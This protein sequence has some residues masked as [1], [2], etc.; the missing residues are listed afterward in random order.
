MASVPEATNAPSLSTIPPDDTAPAPAASS[1]EPGVDCPRAANHLAS[2][3]GVTAVT[4]VRSVA[5]ARWT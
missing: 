3:H 5:L 1:A 4:A 2:G